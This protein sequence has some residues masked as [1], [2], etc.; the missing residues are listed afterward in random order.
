MVEALP[1]LSTTPVDAPDTPR[2]GDAVVAMCVD[3]VWVPLLASLV[4]TGGRGVLREDVLHV[5]VGAMVSVV[6]RVDLAYVAQHM[7]PP[8]LCVSCLCF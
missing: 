2:G 8:Y 7:H 4:D 5:V 3:G 1:P 6:D